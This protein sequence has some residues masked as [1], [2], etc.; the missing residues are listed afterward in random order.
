VIVIA[1][2]CRSAGVAIEEGKSENPIGAAFGEVFGGT[3]R[4]TLAAS[5][6][7]EVSV[8]GAQWGGGHGVFTHFL[9]QGLAGPADTNADGIVKFSEIARWVS[10]RVPT[11]TGDRQHPQRSGM[12]YVSLGYV[13]SSRS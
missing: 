8:E 1:D 4:M 2:A 10:S 9:L 11:E 3:R 6:K 12:G 7:D 13:R 5:G